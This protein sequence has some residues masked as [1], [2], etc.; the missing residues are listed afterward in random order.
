MVGYLSLTDVRQTDFP[1]D[2]SPLNLWSL[3]SFTYATCDKMHVLTNSTDPAER[4]DAVE[5]AK[6]VFERTSIE[7][8]LDVV[9][10]I[11]AQVSRYEFQAGNGEQL[12]CQ[13]RLYCHEPL[14]SNRWF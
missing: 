4:H 1:R 9:D 10:E 8:F 6:N 11:I 12:L 14:V 7:G 2:V 3:M 13:A 5:A